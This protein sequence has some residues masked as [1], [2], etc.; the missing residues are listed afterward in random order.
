M[1]L[2]PL[3]LRWKGP[4]QR[5]VLR[6]GH[7]WTWGSRGFGSLAGT[8]LVSIPPNSSPDLLMT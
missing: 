8:S 7:C 4:P 6:A 5:G 3:L 2:I 1:L